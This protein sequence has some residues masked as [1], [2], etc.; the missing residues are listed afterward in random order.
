MSSADD[1]R[2][3]FSDAREKRGLPPSRLQTGGRGPYDPDMEH[4][5]TALEE[6]MK[7]VKR[8]LADLKVSVATMSGKIDILVA[9]IPSW[10]QAPAGAG[11]LITLMAAL[12]G[13]AKALHW[14]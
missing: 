5:I 13:L 3:E 6:D 2:R 8:D 7:D 4:R 12:V 14:L 9:K 1:L 10:W 11:G